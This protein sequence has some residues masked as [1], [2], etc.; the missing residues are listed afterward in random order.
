[1]NQTLLFNCS[2][3]GSVAVVS[4]AGGSTGGGAGGHSA[5]LPS[6]VATASADVV[7]QS[8]PV[9]IDVYYLMSLN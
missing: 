2:V 9:S 1:L 7:R 4:A 8:N 5:R 3:G 6:S